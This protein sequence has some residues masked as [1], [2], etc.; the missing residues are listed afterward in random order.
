MDV[1]FFRNI[2][3]ILSDFVTVLLNTVIFKKN[4]KWSHSYVVSSLPIYIIVCI[5]VVFIRNNTVI[6]MG[7]SNLFWSEIV[8]ICYICPQLYY[9]SCGTEVTSYLFANVIICFH[10]FFQANIQQV[11]NYLKNTHVTN[12]TKKLWDNVI[13]YI[14]LYKNVH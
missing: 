8:H 7:I 4:S 11:I 1:S 5:V 12:L 3:R 14:T 10:C 2:S 9:N 6:P 13:N